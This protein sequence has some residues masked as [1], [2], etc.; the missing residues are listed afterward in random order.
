MFILLAAPEIFYLFGSAAGDTEYSLISDEGHIFVPF[1][2]PY[3]FF[4][5]TYNSLYVRIQFHC[6]ST[7][8]IKANVAIIFCWIWTDFLHYRF[9]ITDS[10]HS[11]NQNQHLDHTTMPREELKISLL[12]SGV[13]LMTWVGWYQQYTSGSVLTRATQ[14]VYQPVFPSDG[15]LGSLLQR[16]LWIHLFITQ[17]R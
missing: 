10:L 16:Q 11:T 12:H 4:G 17:P 1:S 5:H 15:L 7:V 6:Q 2:I 3:T 13:T 9:I 8:N 14:P